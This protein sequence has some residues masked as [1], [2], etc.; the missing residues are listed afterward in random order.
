MPDREGEGRSLSAVCYRKQDVVPLRRRQDL[1]KQ[2]QHMVSHE[3]VKV[4][5]MEKHHKDT[6]GQDQGERD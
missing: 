5:Y 3:E 4:E 1:V 6:E 2:V